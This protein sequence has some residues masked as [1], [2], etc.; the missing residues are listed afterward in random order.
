MAANNSI[1]VLG[2][3]VDFIP[4]TVTFSKV[5]LNVT[6]GRIALSLTRE[7]AAELWETHVMKLSKKPEAIAL[8]VDWIVKSQDAEHQFKQD[9]HTTSDNATPD[10]SESTVWD[11]AFVLDPTWKENF[12]KR[13][14][15]SNK[16]MP[17]SPA[18]LSSLKSSAIWK[19]MGERPLDDVDKS[20]AN[21]VQSHEADHN[22]LGS[23][24]QDLGALKMYLRNMS[25]EERQRIVQDP[26]FDDKL[27]VFYDNVMH[28]ISEEKLLANQEATH[29]EKA[30]AMPWP[31][32]VKLVAQHR[33]HYLTC[34][35]AD[36]MESDQYEAWYE[37]CL[38]TSLTILENG[39][40]KPYDDAAPR[41]RDYLHLT[42]DNYNSETRVITLH[43]YK[44]SK[45]Y[46]DYSFTVSKETATL[47]E[48]LVEIKGQSKPLFTKTH[49]DWTRTSTSYFNKITRKPL[50]NSLIRHIYISHRQE[51]GTLVFKDDR[52]ELAR[53]MGHS[54]LMQQTDYTKRHLLDDWY[55]EHPPVDQTII[56]SET[57]T[58]VLSDM[59]TEEDVGQSS[60][61]SKRKRGGGGMQFT[62]EENEQLERLLK[63]HDHDLDKVLAE[64]KEKHFIIARRNKNQLRV[65]MRAIAT[66]RI[67]NKED[68]GTFS[69]VKPSPPRK[70]KSPQ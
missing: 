32:I 70:K 47:I 1:V 28:E 51:Q 50:W 4:C 18:T 16:D 66:T 36:R 11:G 21:L 67:A 60:P 23:I 69:R 59:D 34:L 31:E 3:I 58:I 35:Q 64:A 19:R 41:R 29:E 13:N 68:L 9:V 10:V 44:T 37:A 2:D 52:D 40:V 33:A 20:F 30:A 53:R 56:D 14:I 65:R 27:A 15:L 25:T 54:T 43:E 24:S 6:V 26:E 42:S 48:A 57:D 7:E 61:S 49:G 63:K 62:P 38:Y 22:G 8:L 39:G 5:F 17:Y 55:K 12:F 45:T 46:G